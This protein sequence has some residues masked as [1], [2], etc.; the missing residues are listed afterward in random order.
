M[1]SDI[2]PSYSYSA[3]FLRKGSPI[4]PTLR[5]R[6]HFCQYDAIILTNMFPLAQGGSYRATLSQKVCTVAII[7]LYV[8]P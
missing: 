3:D 7:E 6:E 1:V 5:Q 2:L 8:Q 4:R